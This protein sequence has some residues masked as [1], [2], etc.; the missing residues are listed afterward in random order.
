MFFLPES[1]RWLIRQGK[2]EAAIV[3]L[4]RITGF[5]RDDPEIIAQLEE[6]NANLQEELALGESSY[7]DCFKF[8][9][10]KIAFRTLSGIFIQAFQQLTG[11]KLSTL[12]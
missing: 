4:C 10:N 12:E 3:S 7:V 9:K 11:S 1:P 5:S 2:E 8:T 6:I